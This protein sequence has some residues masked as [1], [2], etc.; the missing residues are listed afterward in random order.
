MEALQ[1]NELSNFSR[2]LAERPE[3]VLAFV[4]LLGTTLMM[5]ASTVAMTIIRRSPL[6]AYERTIRRI[7]ADPEVVKN[8][9]GS[10]EELA[11]IVAAALAA[12]PKPEVRAPNRGVFAKISEDIT[13]DVAGLIGILVTAVILIM[14]VSSK[15]ADIPDT[16]FAGWAT[17]LGYY[18]GKAA[19]H[20]TKEN[21]TPK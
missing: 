19:S 7:L 6:D 12:V 4:T 14:I 9:G 11:N 1:S 16:V 15:T 10:K 18:F 3:I 20:P 5:L 13:W 8:A 2:A 21:G 17:I